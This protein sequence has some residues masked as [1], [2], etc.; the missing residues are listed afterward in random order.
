MAGRGWGPWVSDKAIAGTIG[1]GRRV[2]AVEVKTGCTI[3]TTHL[4]SHVQTFGWQAPGETKNGVW[5]GPG[6]ELSSSGPNHECLGTQGRGLRLEAL[7][8]SMYSGWGAMTK[9]DGVRLCMQAHLAGT[10]WQSIRC[11]SYID[12][13]KRQS[14]S[15]AMVGTTGQGRQIEALRMWYDTL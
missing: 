5:C 11:S 8:F 3:P 7:K 1:E 9:A 6:F 13:S 2:E 10:G 12:P 14:S 15:T 4:E